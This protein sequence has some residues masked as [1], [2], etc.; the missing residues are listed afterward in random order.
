MEGS[1]PGTFQRKFPGACRFCKKGGFPPLGKWAGAV[2][3]R[4]PFAKKFP[5]KLPGKA[6]QGDHLGKEEIAVALR[7]QVPLHF[8]QFGSVADTRLLLDIAG[9]PPCALFSL[10]LICSRFAISKTS[11]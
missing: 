3:P 2:T 7:D 11:T 10:L 4:T 6:P 8:W 1:P 9:S 5:S